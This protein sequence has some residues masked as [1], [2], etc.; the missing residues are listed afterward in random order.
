LIGASRAW[1][2]MLTGRIIEAD[3]A[4]RIGLVLRVVTDEELQADA[5]KTASLIA[6]N[7]S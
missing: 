3:E 7:A 2:L 1:E 6:A 4:D 5:L